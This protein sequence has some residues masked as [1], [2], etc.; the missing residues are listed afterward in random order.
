MDGQVFFSMMRGFL[1]YPVGRSHWLEKALLSRREVPLGGNRQLNLG[2]RPTQD[3]K[4]SEGGPWGS[5]K[6]FPAL[7]R[8]PTPPLFVGGGPRKPGAAIFRTA[9]GNDLLGTR[10]HSVVGKEVMGLVP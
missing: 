3:W 2:L 8:N 4:C 10:P 7:S 1:L 5:R 6:R 9:E